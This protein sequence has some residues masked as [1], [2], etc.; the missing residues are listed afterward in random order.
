MEN[1]FI[2]FVK[3]STWYGKII[4]KVTS[5]SINHTFFI[6]RSNEWN[7]WCAIDID[8]RGV[9]QV[10]ATSTLK[11][12]VKLRC[13]YCKTHDLTKGILAHKNLLGKKYDFASIFG[14]LLKV[15]AKKW[16]HKTIKNPVDNKHKYICSEY[17]TMCIAASGIEW[18]SFMD[19][20]SVQPEELLEEVLDRDW[21]WGEIQGNV[22]ELLRK[23]TFTEY[24]K[25]EGLIA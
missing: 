23:R 4:R 14:S 17:L 3:E 19:F 18:A 10:A 25:Q 12:V 13:F 24:L 22:P 5:G 2:C 15:I 21:Q 1:V 20:N 8:Y 9:I 16:F 6:F 11:D 7:D